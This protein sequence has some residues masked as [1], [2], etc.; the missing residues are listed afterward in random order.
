M[1]KIS[2]LSNKP[3]PTLAD[4][5]PLLD[6]A[7][8]N[9][10]SATLTEIANA[11]INAITPS[12]II[13]VYAGASAPSGWFLCQGQAISRTTYAA[14]FTAIGTTYGAGDGSTT[15]NLPDLR[16]RVPLGVGT[17]SANGATAHT[18]GQVGGEETHVLSTSEIPA[19]SHVMGMYTSNNEASGYGLASPGSG[20]GNR[21]LV[22]TTVGNSTNNT[23]GG[24]THNNLTPYVGMNFI[25][26]T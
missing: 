26:K 19:H 21:V 24:G 17:S 20:F 11:I 2:Q 6:V 7:A 25:I 10:K 14:L 5:L 15:F 13:D 9:T 8:G 22:A 4:V 3:Q 18:L 1:P 23:G 16:G 12:G